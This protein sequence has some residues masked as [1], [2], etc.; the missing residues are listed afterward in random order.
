[1]S[2]LAEILQDEAGAEIEGITA[3]GGFP[4]GQDHQR[5]QEPH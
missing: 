2:K 1:M 4:G 5:G 3:A